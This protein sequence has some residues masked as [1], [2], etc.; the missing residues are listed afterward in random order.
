MQLLSTLLTVYMLG[1]GALACLK[2]DMTYVSTPGRLSGT[3]HDNG[4][5]V[6]RI[7]KEGA[8]QYTNKWGA[9]DYG[10]H[11]EPLDCIEGWDLRLR[12]ENDGGPKEWF[13]EV[14]VAGIGAREVELDVEGRR[15]EVSKMT[16][17]VWDCVD[18]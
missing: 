15:E 9:H 2:V 6:C 13:L 1:T 5:Q 16:A 3:V 14:Q 12:R 4:I 11:S 8:Y 17:A 18:E 7:N 10:K